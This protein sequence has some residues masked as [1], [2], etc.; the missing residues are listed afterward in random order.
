MENLAGIALVEIENPAG[1]TEGDPVT[2]KEDENS[3][4]RIA[5][6][7]FPTKTLRFP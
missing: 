7:R 3:K 4:M 1:D 2:Y 6:I 5:A